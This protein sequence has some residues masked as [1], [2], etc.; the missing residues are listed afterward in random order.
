MNN[1]IK[2]KILSPEIIKKGWG[3]EKVIC[4]NE[5]FCGKILHFN[6]GNKF[7]F[8]FHV[9]KREVFYV[10]KGV[11]ELTTINYLDGTKYSYT[12]REGDII[13][14]DRLVP[15]QIYAVRDVDI[16]EIS[17]HHEDSDSYR[18]APGDSQKL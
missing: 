17:S 1:A 13:E 12:F 10:L 9:K 7:S 2:I 15:H 6:E 4:N 14:I 16:I 11:L 18:I 5:E 3:Y 8:H